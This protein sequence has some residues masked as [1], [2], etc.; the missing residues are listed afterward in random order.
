MSVVGF[1][2]TREAV[3]LRRR[4]RTEA[5]RVIFRVSALYGLCAKGT[6]MPLGALGSIDTGRTGNVG[7]KRVS[8]G[9]TSDTPTHDGGGPIDG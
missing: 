1:E 6:R 7:G 9:P 2:L 8:G 3:E 5:D 4:Q